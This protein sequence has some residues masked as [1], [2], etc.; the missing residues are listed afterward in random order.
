[1][2]NMM[3]NL[4]LI[5]FTVLVMAL[6][7]AG[8][9]LFARYRDQ[10]VLGAV[11]QVDAQEEGEGYRYTLSSNEKLYILS[12]SLSSQAL[13][14]SEQYALTRSRTDE[15]YGEPEGNYAF[16]V[17]H[18][19]P[20][21][22]EITDTQ[23]YD[24]CNRGLSALKELGIL[25]DTVK[26]VEPGTYDA[27]LYSAI[28]VLEPRNN[29][30]VW[31]LEMSNIQKNADKENHLINAYIDADDG[32]MY[33]FY[34]RTPRRWEEMDPDRIMETWSSYM[35][36]VQ[37]RPYDEPNPLMETT[38]YFKKYACPGPAGEMTIVTVGFYE[39]INEFFLKISK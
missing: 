39:G 14:E 1:M 10:S 6:S 5:L 22:E 4:F 27:V 34:V 13:P 37:P 8:P 3:K 20:S 24:V 23:I 11:H 7:I 33:E 21:G 31:K 16:V 32:K 19:G 26:D 12:E 30:A 28:D 35:G 15:G 36:L 9:E 18:R 25:P 2:G 29:V 38:P 17:N